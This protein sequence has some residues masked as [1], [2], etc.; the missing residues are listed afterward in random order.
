MNRHVFGCFALLLFWACGN[1]PTYQV[2]L[3][4][5][6]YS[7]DQNPTV[8]S[9]GLNFQAK[10]NSF[11]SWHAMKIT[12]MGANVPL[13][14]KN[15]IVGGLNIKHQSWKETSSTLNFLSS[16][17][18]SED[19]IRDA[20]INSFVFGVPDSLPFRFRVTEITGEDLSMKVDESRNVVVK[21]RLS[22]GDQNANIAMPALIKH[23]PDLISITPAELFKLNVRS[24]SPLANQIN[25]VE[26]ITQLLSFVPG[27]EMQDDV[28]IDFNLEFE[29]SCR[30]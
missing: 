28:T 22:I 30:K 21:G 5:S 29:P 17:T 3:R 6:L 19:P 23:M 27:I 18:D 15:S 12:A 4:R 9:S 2:P 13:T 11:I 1:A 8:C 26:K 7:G 14:G 24:L 20:R 10:Q 16:S 25:L